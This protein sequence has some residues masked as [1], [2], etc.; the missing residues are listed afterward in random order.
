MKKLLI[1][2]LACYNFTAH[3][4]DSLK[5]DAK[6]VTATVYYGYGA[7]LTHETNVNV[8]PAVKQIV[9][10][11]LSTSI[12]ENSLQVSIPADVVL[13]SQKYSVVSPTMAP[14]TSPLLKKLQDSMLLLNAALRRNNNLVSIEEQTMDKTGKLIEAVL[15]NNGNKTVRSEEVLTLVNAY[16]AKIE[17]SKTNIFNLKET[18]ADLIKIQEELNTR[19]AD[20]SIPKEKT[21]APFGQ[22]MLQVICKNSGAIPV[23]FSYFTRNA[24]WTALYDLRVNTKTNEIKLVYKASVTQTTGINWKQ[25]HLTLSTGNPSFGG[26]PPELNAH[27]LQF[28]VPQIYT[29]VSRSI[30]EKSAGANIQNKELD[31]VEITAL[32]AVRQKKNLG[33]ST[34][35]VD[36]ATLQNYM[37]LSESQLNTNFEID[38]PYDIESDGQLHAVTIKEEKIN[39]MLK[40]Y[41]VPLMDKDAYLL[42]AVSDWQNLNLLPGMANIIMDNTYLGK[43]FID[44]NNVAD[45]LNLSL[46]KDRRVAIKRT[47]IKEFTS[48]KTNGSTSIKTFS[49]EIVIK[50]NKL[51]DVDLELKDQFPISSIRDIEVKLMDG[52]NAEINNDNGTLSWKLQLKPGE[53]K[54]MKFSYTIKYPKDKMIAG[55]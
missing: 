49:Y 33:Y 8:N 39:A 16:T 45:T 19:I 14:Y 48:T 2:I 26:V 35:T 32:G 29:D 37:T 7:E 11:H 27:F 13:L 25:A 41:A 3:A 10:Q 6:L 18:A 9:I 54:K 51:T 47:A 28:Y 17:K 24:G 1:A 42:A 30:Y 4:Q 5:T 21:P 46:G 55:L 22:L 52:S 44:A 34:S 38:L 36:P 12:D 31:A 50:N 53:S 23:S 43:S 20:A 15:T 40:N